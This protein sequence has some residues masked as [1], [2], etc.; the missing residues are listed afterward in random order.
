VD[1]K[2]VKEVLVGLNDLSLI[3][4]KGVN[5]SL[6]YGKIIGAPVSMCWLDNGVLLG[7]QEGTVAFYEGKKPRW[8]AKSSH[9]V[10]KVMA[11]RTESEYLAIIGRK[12]GLV[13]LKDWKNKGETISK[14]KLHE[15]MI[16]MHIHD[17]RQEDNEQLICVLKSGNVKGL[18]IYEEAKKNDKKMV[19]DEVKLEQ[20]S[21]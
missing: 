5:I 19:A 11:H 14:V 13:E 2:G 1:I 12:D 7:T 20:Q 4:Y 6:D 17:F 9:P 16:G 21:F 10:L 15:E 18:N 3:R 8:R